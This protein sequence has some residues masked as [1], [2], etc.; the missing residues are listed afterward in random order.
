M[1]V[2]IYQGRKDE[3][4][5]QAEQG[6]EGEQVGEGGEGWRGWE[7]SHLKTPNQGATSSCQDSDQLRS[8]H[9]T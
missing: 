3:R 5:R 1:W 2:S 6:Q 8:S 4:E 9:Q 7:R